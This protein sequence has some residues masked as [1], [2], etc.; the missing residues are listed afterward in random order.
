M[1]GLHGWALLLPGRVRFET[2]LRPSRS[3]VALAP[4]CSLLACIKSRLLSGSTS[5]VC[6][7]LQEFKEPETDETEG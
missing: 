1:S 3:W 4:N 7:R 2:I 5:N 6:L